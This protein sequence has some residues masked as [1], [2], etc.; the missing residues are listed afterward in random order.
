MG[1]IKEKLLD[2]VRE[3]VNAIANDTYE[4]LETL[5]QLSSD[6]Q[7]EDDIKAGIKDLRQFITSNYNGWAEDE[8]KPYI[9]KTFLEENCG[10]D[11]ET[12]AEELQATGSSDMTYT[13][14]TTDNDPN[15]FWLELTFELKEDHHISTIL[16]INF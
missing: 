12:V 13:L 10:E 6:W 11:L 9:I 3:I 14:V 5:V 4:N 8:G 7:T 16:N 2:I 1:N 15:Y